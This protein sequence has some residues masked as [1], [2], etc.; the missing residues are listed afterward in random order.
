M[1]GLLHPGRRFAPVRDDSDELP[2]QGPGRRLR[3][4]GHL[5][6]QG[7]QGGP[8]DGHGEHRG[9]LPEG[10]PHAHAEG[11]R[12]E[13]DPGRRLFAHLL[14]RDDFGRGAQGVP[15]VRLAAHL[16]HVFRHPLLRARLQPVRDVLRGRPEE[17]RAVRHGR[18]RRAQGARTR[19]TTRRR[20][21]ASTSSARR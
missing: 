9:Q 13:V 3:E 17:P 5:V 7:P 12:V 19:S 16:R 18:R 14:E 11:R 15:E 1:G 20:P 8:G 6:E 21:G 4:P 10:H 2:R